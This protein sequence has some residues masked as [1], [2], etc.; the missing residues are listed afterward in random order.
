MPDLDYTALTDPYDRKAAHAT[1]KAGGASVAVAV[2]CSAVLAGVPL[3]VVG[4]FLAIWDPRLVWV[5]VAVGIVV[6]L[7]AARFVHRDR[8]RQVERRWRLARFARANR[9]HYTP[10]VPS[11]SRPGA[12]FSMGIN[13]QSEDQ[14]TFSEPR[15]FTVGRHTCTA[16]YRNGVPMR[17]GFATTRLSTPAP[18]PHLMLLSRADSRGHFPL[19]VGPAT[20][21]KIAVTGPGADAF[22]VDGP[23]GRRDEVQALLDRTLFRPEVLEVLTTRRVDLEIVDDCLIIHAAETVGT[24]PETWRWVLEVVTCAAESL[25]VPVTSG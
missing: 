13:R 12:V 24:D 15:S 6:V 10:V 21:V 18:L 20:P 2:G 7:L 23:M 22:T 14:F 4:L 19:P 9:L 16:G 8:E 11:P 17:W 1:T 25:E 5:A 3:T